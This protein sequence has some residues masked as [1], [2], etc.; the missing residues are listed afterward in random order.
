GIN[1]P[2]RE[3][4]SEKTMLDIIKDKA[5]KEGKTVVYPMP[6]GRANLLGLAKFNLSHIARSGDVEARNGAIRSLAYAVCMITND[7][8]MVN[9]I[10]RAFEEKAD[11][12]IYFF[13][14]TFEIALPAVEKINFDIMKQIWESEAEVLRA[15]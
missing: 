3:F 9:E 15:L 7:L 14:N 4:L 2:I 5:V 6:Y 13:E 1:I 11:I 8:D 12:N 10:S